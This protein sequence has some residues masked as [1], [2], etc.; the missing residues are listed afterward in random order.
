M[1][2]VAWGTPRG[3]RSGEGKGGAPKPGKA[4]RGEK[5]RGRQRSVLSLPAHLAKGGARMAAP[6]RRLSCK[7]RGMSSPRLDGKP[8]DSGP[9]GP[10]FSLQDLTEAQRKE[11]ELAFTR[12]DR[13]DSG[14]IGIG[15]MR[16]VSPP[17]TRAASPAHSR[18]RSPRSSPGGRRSS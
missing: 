18:P 14:K 6:I 10:T 8:E 5:E 13:D 17:T 7:L 4:V 12:F 1:S 9:A 15:E 16:S 11:V 3:E 2:T